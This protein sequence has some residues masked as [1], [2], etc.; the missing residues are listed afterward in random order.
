MERKNTA[1]ANRR[2]IG[3]VGLKPAGRPP[4]RLSSTADLR[5]LQRLMTHVLVR[6]LAPGDKLQPVWIDGRPTA[7]VVGEF[8]KP[9]DRLTAVER[10]EIYNRMYW[11]RLTDCVT[12]DSP[13]LRALL[14]ERKFS[15]LV[16]GYLAKYP[17]RSFTLRNLCS[18][19]AQFIAEEPLLTAPRTA[20]ALDVARFEWA[21]TVAFDGESRPS[22]EPE[23][24]GRT[25][26]GRLRMG[27]QPYLS[28]LSLG[29][30]VDDFVVAVKR[31]G[32]LRAE[33]SNAIG[34]AARGS[35]LRRVKPPRRLR[36]HLAVHRHSG[37]LYYKRLEPAAFR[38]LTALREGRTLTRAIA[39][40]GRRVRPAEIQEWFAL[41]MK[42]GWLCRPDP[43]RP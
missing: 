34:T 13:G 4:A 25:A 24:I 29:Y 21:Q 11:F 32:A 37:R 38:I 15:R 10:V 35:R 42:L 22:F 1:I 3:P 26:P 27:L 17:S 8:I 9:N 28:L 23:K 16:R 7:E 2:D 33:A 41:W 6:P 39:A 31:R 20:L 30:P 19:L 5:A 36:I 43:L 18:R 12:D 40:A 14:G